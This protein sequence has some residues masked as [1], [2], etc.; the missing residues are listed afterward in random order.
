MPLNPEADPDLDVLGEAEAEGVMDWEGVGA[1]DR[2]EVTLPVTVG[3]TVREAVE[4]GVGE[5]VPVPP[6]PPP[7]LTPEPVTDRVAL[8]EPL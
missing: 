8:G 1:G 5:G 3:V 6:P 4:Q 7:L 2:E